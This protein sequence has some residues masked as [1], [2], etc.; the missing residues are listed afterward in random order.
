MLDDNRD[1]KMHWFR[2]EVFWLSIASIQ[3]AAISIIHLH[4]DEKKH[5]KKNKIY[6]CSAKSKAI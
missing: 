1:G 2:Q 5:L 6:M 3:P 4:T